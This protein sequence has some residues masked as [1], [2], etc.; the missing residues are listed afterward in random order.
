MCK[1]SISSSESPDG[2]LDINKFSAKVGRFHICLL[3]DAADQPGVM[4]SRELYSCVGLFDEQG[5]SQATR[6]LQGALTHPDGEKTAARV[7]EMLKMP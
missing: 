1:R 2:I 6:K 5:Q 3:H 4:L 7:S